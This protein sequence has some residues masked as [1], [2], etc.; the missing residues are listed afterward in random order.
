MPTIERS[1][2]VAAYCCLH[3]SD[4]TYKRPSADPSTGGP[5]C[6]RLP[7]RGH[8]AAVLRLGAK[9][10]LA[11]GFLWLPPETL[12]QMCQLCD[13]CPRP[14]ENERVFSYRWGH[15]QLSLP[16]FPIRTAPQRLARRPVGRRARTRPAADRSGRGAWSARPW[17]P[18]SRARWGRPAC[19][20]E[21]AVQSSAYSG[22]HGSN[23]TPRAARRAGKRRIRHRLRPSSTRAP[24][25]FLA[26][27]SNQILVIARRC[28]ASGGTPIKDPVPGAE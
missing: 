11:P 27:A 14:L 24:R 3:G 17:K 26:R 7:D 21:R 1:V 19:P 25:G 16:H 13:F 4:Q 10:V 6:S 18:D 28:R 5:R 20:I 22:W 2:A 15:G 9:S 23:S 8:R 12:G